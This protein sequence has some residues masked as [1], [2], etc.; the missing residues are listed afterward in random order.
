MSLC[1]WCG[2]RIR[3]VVT[4]SGST[5]PLDPDPNADGN[6][7]IEGGRARVLSAIEHGQPAGHT[8][9]WMPHHA[10]CPAAPRRINRRSR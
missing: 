2:G 8:A 3:W 9:R 1:K 7:V 5:M 10:T 4:E 6:V